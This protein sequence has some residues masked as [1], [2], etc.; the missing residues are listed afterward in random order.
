MNNSV[1]EEDFN[2]AIENAVGRIT[3]INKLYPSQTEL[4][5]SLV[6]QKNIFCTAPTN[7]GGLSYEDLIQNFSIFRFI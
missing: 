2:L 1:S 3:G 6:E 7:S 4:L 5:K